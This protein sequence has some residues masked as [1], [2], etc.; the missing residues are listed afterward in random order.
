VYEAGIR[1][2]KATGQLQEYQLAAGTY[3]LDIR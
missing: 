2:V 3:R 1:A